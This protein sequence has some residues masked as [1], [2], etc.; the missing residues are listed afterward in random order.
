MTGVPVALI[1][2]FIA[3]FENDRSAMLTESEPLCRY[4]DTRSDGLRNWDVY[5]PGVRAESGT[6]WSMR[7]SDSGFCVSSARRAAVFG[8]IP[9]P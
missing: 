1:R 7:V 9:T 6:L 3:D 2:E 5:I 8:A 4:I